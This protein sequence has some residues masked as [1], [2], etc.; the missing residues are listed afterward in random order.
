[1]AASLRGD[2]NVFPAS[3]KEII[4]TINISKENVADFQAK[5]KK[6]LGN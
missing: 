2:K 6:L 5:L 1:M 3:G 4:P